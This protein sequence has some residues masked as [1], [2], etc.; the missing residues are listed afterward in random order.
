MYF[1]SEPYFHDNIFD[2]DFLTNQQQGL[3]NLGPKYDRHGGIV[4]YSLAGRVEWFERNK[5]QT[6]ITDLINRLEHRTVSNSQQLAAQGPNYNRTGKKN[7]SLIDNQS[8]KSKLK[9]QKGIMRFFSKGN[10]VFTR[11]QALK[12]IEKIR[13][14]IADNVEAQKAEVRR[15]PIKDQIQQTKE[16]R[17]LDKHREN[18]QFW[19]NFVVEASGKLERDPSCSS[20]VQDQYFRATR[21]AISIF[22]EVKNDYDRFG[23]SVWINTLRKNDSP[24]PPSF[25]DDDAP[26]QPRRL[27]KHQHINVYNDLPQAFQTAQIQGRAKNIEIIKK[28]TI[29]DLRG[30]TIS[31]PAISADTS[32]IAMPSLASQSVVSLNNA[33]TRSLNAFRQQREK[34]QYY[35][36]R[37]KQIEP[38][39]E[40]FRELINQQ[41]EF[42]HLAVQGISQL[43]LESQIV[44]RAQNMTLFKMHKLSGEP[45]A[46]QGDQNRKQNPKHVQ[47]A[48]QEEE[49][50][51]ENYGPRQR[52]EKSHARESEGSQ[53]SRLST[54]NSPLHSP[55]LAQQIL[56]SIF[57]K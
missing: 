42:E 56:P 55:K 13:R 40:E 32:S 15:L 2:K 27:Q 26:T 7:Q 14:R 50:I 1:P 51:V 37:Y 25:E 48:Q 24:A 41:D 6:K 38:L 18:E 11:E 23:S 9:E 49:I 4:P 8:T 12:E 57:Q 34:N 21:E 16:E 19:R 33:S 3:T 45:Q 22:D 52:T 36:Q 5:D 47:H 44:Q 17:I 29:T 53:L 54:I 39:L 30:S 10:N 20:L 31:F 35:N 28:P 46:K 43:A